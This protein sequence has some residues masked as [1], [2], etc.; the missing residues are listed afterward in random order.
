MPV[1]FIAGEDF[2]EGALV[3]IDKPLGWTSFDVVNKIKYALKNKMGFKKIKVG[4]AGTLD[5]LAT[6]V[7]VVCV[8]RM[9][10]QIET[11]MAGETE[12]S[13]TIV[14]GKVTA[15]FDLETDPEGDFPTDQLNLDF[16]RSKA[17]ELTGE[18]IQ[19]PPI[20]SAKKIDG[21]RAFA[22]AREGKEV[23]VRPNL[24]EVKSFEIL[25]FNDNKATFKVVCSK[26]TYIRSLAN[27]LGKLAGSGA[28]LSELRRLKSGDH[29]VDEAMTVE[30]MVAFI[31]QKSGETTAE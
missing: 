1:E 3:V 17:L 16:I 9:T 11:L 14:F 20:F 13:G 27:D 31:A 25:D 29:G 4:H 26:G 21:K 8:G 30:E 7:L 5:P 6:G 19:Y 28:Y 24:V 23:Q 2:R 10:R 15:S 12:Y 22:Y 18:I